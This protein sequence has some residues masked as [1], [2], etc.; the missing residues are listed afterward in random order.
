MNK[1]I[2]VLLPALLSFAPEMASPARAQT[3]PGFSPRQYV[4]YQTTAPLQIDGKPSEEAWAK[5]AWTE[6][7]VDIEGDR[8]PRPPF[9]T[10]A[11]MLWDDQY[12]YI[13]A[14]LEEPHVWATLTERESVIFQD[15]DFE[16]FIDPDG[17]THNYYEFEINALG[18]E[19]DLMLA[20]PY[21]DGGP[22][23][24]GWDIR[25]IRSAVHVDGTLNYAPDTDRKWTVEIAMPW[26][27]LKECA[28]ERRKPKDGEQWRVNFSR[29]QW[30]TDIV[31]GQYRKRINP[32][33][34][35]PYPEDNWVWSP[36][37]AIDMHRPE[38]WGF[39]Q[40]SERKVGS[41]PASFSP[42][43]DE[44]V[45]WALRQVYYAQKK[46]YTATGKYSSDLSQLGYPT[47]KTSQ[48][49]VIPQIQVT[50][51][52]FEASAPSTDGKARWHIRSD[53]RVWKEGRD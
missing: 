41:S 38:M 15:N 1:Y 37:G 48:P 40:F 24:N 17:D 49:P 4:C 42:N 11:K 6:A 7:F 30:Q 44:A 35:K 28:P 23:I 51:T 2:F 14:E 22:A 16:V 21:R 29:V 34:Q 50:A 33:T 20:K 47:V 46:Y 36:Q 52:M 31:N 12:F 5:A 9:T 39:V 10:R 8:K 32:Q 25:G 43:P 13:L 18:T 26:E 53:G 19:W 27:I 45:K 3:A